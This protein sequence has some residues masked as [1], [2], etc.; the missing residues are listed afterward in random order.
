MSTQLRQREAPAVRVDQ[1]NWH[2]CE[3]NVSEEGIRVRFYSVV[4]H[5]VN[6]WKVT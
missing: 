4:Q 5:V 6:D 2:H 3:T 1:G